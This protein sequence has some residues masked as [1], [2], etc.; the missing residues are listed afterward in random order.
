[1][2]AMVVR[3]RKYGQ[4]ILLLAV[5]MLLSV[6]SAAVGAVLMERLR[7]CLEVLIPS[8]FGGMAVCH[9]M[10]HMGAL[11]ALDRG[12]TQLCKGKSG[13]GRW[14]G[15]YVLSQLAGYPMGAAL[16]GKM[17][18]EGQLSAQQAQRLSY[19]C[20]GAG[21]S[22]LVGLAGAQLLGSTKAGWLLFLCCC[23][24][25]LVVAAFLWRGVRAMP[26]SS[27]AAAHD[28][29]AQAMVRSAQQAMEGLLR[30]CAVVLLFG[31]IRFL[32]E[33]IGLLPLL[34]ELGTQLGLD[35]D[36]TGALFSAILDITLLGEVCTAGLPYNVLLP[37]MAALL[38]FGGLCVQ[39]QCISL[40]VG[41]LSFLRLLAVRLICALLSA[42]FCVLLLPLFPPAAVMDAFVAQASV[43]QSGSLL[44]G[45]LILCTGF[46]I[47]LKKDWTN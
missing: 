15:V 37:A 11:E 5:L 6:Q 1:M 42:L 9:L 14:L 33:V 35:R 16:L 36:V 31:L 40:G 8:L 34:C 45:L 32:G 29:M 22:F 4:M 12:C 24:A 46:P 43:S 25:N 23:L 3:R 39:C 41:G 38:S 19:V 17:E 20:F 26:S 44:P 28:P 7:L 47:I 21:P 18:Q 2:L 10:M 27:A 13:A 30:I